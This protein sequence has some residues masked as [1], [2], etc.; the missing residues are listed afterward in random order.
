MNLDELKGKQLDDET[1]EK[2][3]KYVM[4]IVGQRDSARNESITGRKAQKQK[5]ETTE[6]QV[7]R[8]LEKLG[9]DTFEDAEALPDQKGAAEAAKQFEARVKRL[10]REN[11]TLAQARDE[12]LGKFRSNAT[13]AA[14]AEAIGTHEFIAPDLVQSYIGS[15]VVWEGD[16]LLFKA[17]DGKLVTV[18]DGVS[19]FARARPELLKSTGAGGAGVRPSNA[20]GGTG[21]VKSMSRADFDALP[22][23]QRME[24]SKGGVQLT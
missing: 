17:D 13:R 7:A 15:R 20:G 3:Q 22:P 14:I 21:A 9:V 6:A 24:L 19:G 23:Q 18:R 16:D 11:Q 4:D 2:L 10:E 1:F 8:L 12:A 5:L